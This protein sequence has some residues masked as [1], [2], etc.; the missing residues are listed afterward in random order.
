M[1]NLALYIRIGTLAL[2]ALFLVFLLSR[3]R[4]LKTA[5]TLSAVFVSVVFW[6][7]FEFI[8]TS[9]DVSE[10]TNLL[11]WRLTFVVVYIMAFLLL[12]FVYT[13]IKQPVWKILD[14]TL[15][16]TVLIFSVISVFTDK[17]IRGIKPESLSWGREYFIG[18]LFFLGALVIV[19]PLVYS[20][21]LIIKELRRSQDQNKRKQLW[22]VLLGLAI[23][24]VVGTS[25]NLIFPI[26]GISFPKLASLGVVGLIACF[27][28]AIYRY[29]AIDIQV[30]KFK[31]STRLII[32]FLAVTITSSIAGFIY[33]FQESKNLLK[34]EVY[35]QLEA[36]SKTRVS[37]IEFF[38]RE[39]I[40]HVNS[41]TDSITL[42]QALMINKNA[43]NYNDIYHVTQARANE[44]VAIRDDYLGLAVYNSRGEV[45]LSTSGLIIEEDENITKSLAGKETFFSRVYFSETFQSPAIN[46][47]ASFRSENEI[48]GV[49]KLVINIGP[50]YAI[51][52]DHSGLRETGE[53]FLVNRDGLV[54]TPLRLMPD[55][56]LTLSIKDIHKECF[57][58]KGVLKGL[59]KD[60]RGIQTEGVNTYIESMDWCFLA[61]IDKEEL[62]KYIT[63]AFLED[64]VF[65][66]LIVILLTVL[67]G[68]FSAQ[69]ITRPLE[70]LRKDVN[71][72]EAGDYN[73]KAGT[74]AKDEIGDLSRAFD[75]MTSTIKRSRTE[76]DQKVKEQTEEIVKKQKLLSDQ[77]KAVLNVLEDV[78][79]E[80]NNVAR[81]KDK[82]DAILH[83]IGDAVFA[84]NNKLEITM[85]NEIAENISGYR[86][87]EV[88]G[89]LYNKILKFVNE[90]DG[91]TNDSY[92]EKVI[93]TGE[94]QEMPRN[95]NLV[96]KTGEQVPVADSASPLRDQDGQ[97]SGAVMVFRDV[98]KERAIDKAK[99]EF[100]S[101]ASH[102][103]RTPLT[104]IN[105]YAEM[106]LSGDA[107]KL[108]PDQ[109]S[110]LEEI[111]KGN[112]RMVSLVNSLLNVSR[113]ELGTFVVEPKNMDIRKL[114][115]QEIKLLLPQT[116][117][118]NIT[119]AKKY[120]KNLTSYKADAK[121]LAMVFQNLLSNSVKY[122]NEGGEVSLEIKKKEHDI[123][124]I[125]KDNG[126][127]IPK[128]QHKN[129]FTKLFRADNVRQ[130]DT[131]GTGLGLY[132][133]K[134]I[135]TQAGGS[136]KFE[137]EEGKGT[138]FYI[139]LPLEGMKKK[140]GTK[141]LD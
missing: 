4:Q 5:K 63:D 80:K 69:T 64:I 131:E 60:Y 31:I 84:I 89:K 73:H 65:A 33:F 6:F 103:L 139:S 108:T 15:L 2:T 24:I 35:F 66:F 83:S 140:A 50:I 32:I 106:V 75:K 93:K 57:E 77:Q 79:E 42:Q 95:I 125:V 36:I 8:G 130:M 45:E 21:Y 101:L 113:L 30:T 72:I 68:R 111:Y 18:D 1:E 117:K 51:T 129:I 20:A 25:T 55:S 87:E 118:K 98:E 136:I 12:R 43:D 44:I 110:Y 104:S 102:Q 132:I 81:E 46:A 40:N 85:F 107:G 120:D 74:E 38:L 10:N 138:T 70:K 3:S 67:I 59:Q 58:K 123:Q 34:E 61:E 76:I 82:I 56:A 86:E 71:I 127:G 9:F 17:I 41:L 121:L 91:K 92:I 109:K 26:L 122:N 47:Y 19:L 90:K 112:Q 37:S 53:T 116:K 16:I 128:K 100:V 105:W 119:I 137:S 49:L 11:F 134:E 133:I 88:L 99:T 52:T 96:K 141:T 114:A 126:F 135:V 13:L 124:I 97:V 28:Y 115:D 27:T 14:Q 54:L 78:E 94:P 39:K 62:D 48:I 23:P 29:E 22:W 7:S